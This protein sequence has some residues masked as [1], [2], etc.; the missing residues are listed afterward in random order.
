MLHAGQS[1]SVHDIQSERI[2]DLGDARGLCADGFEGRLIRLAGVHVRL[3]H[4][5][6]QIAWRKQGRGRWVQSLIQLIS[7]SSSDTLS[8][9]LE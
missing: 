3:G 5:G 8:D 7:A 1:P 4:A 2:S 6:A 9:L